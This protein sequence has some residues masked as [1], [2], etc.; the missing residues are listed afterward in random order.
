VINALRPRLFVPSV[1]AI[2]MDRLWN[3]GVRGIIMDLDNTLVS[4]NHD[5]ASADLMA[6]IVVAKH[7]PFRLCLVSNNLGAR[8][9]RFASLLGVP[10]IPRAAKPR[11]RAFRRAM[12]L[13]GTEAQ[14]TAV[15]GDQI[16]TD[17]LGGN[18]LKCYTILVAPL[19]EHEFWTTRLIRRVERFV[20]PATGPRP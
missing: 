3:Q 10:A 14:S 8:V 19:A 5:E 12:Q 20:W 17:V 18:R 6:W 9:D 11:R 15:V 7:R 16:F 2:D 4:W 13:M 1:F